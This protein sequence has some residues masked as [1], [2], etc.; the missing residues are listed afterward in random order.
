MLAEGNTR[1]QQDEIKQAIRGQWALGSQAFIDTL[2]PMANRRLQ[3][4]QRGRPR[5]NMRQDGA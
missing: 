4:G 2:E 5:K 3:P 1:A